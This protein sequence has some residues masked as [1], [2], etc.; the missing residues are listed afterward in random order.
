MWKIVFLFLAASVAVGDGTLV[1]GFRTVDP[2]DEGVQN[3]VNFAVAVHNRRSNAM[4]RSTATEVIEAKT[5]V[6]KYLDFL[7]CYSSLDSEFI[8]MLVGR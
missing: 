1:G 4:F 7:I 8:N 5:Q 2:K 6:G 3:A